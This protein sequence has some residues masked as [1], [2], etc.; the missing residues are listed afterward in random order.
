MLDTGRYLARIGYTGPREPVLDT[1]RALHKAHLRA[2]PFENLDIGLGRAIALDEAAVFDKIVARRRGGFCYELN[3]L[4]ALLLRALGFR[5]TLLSARVRR[6]GA[7]PGPDYGPEFDHLAL[8]VNLDEP[9]LADV[10]FGDA[11][12]L[13]LRLDARGQQIDG[14]RANPIRARAPEGAWRDCYRIARG[15][16]LR[17]LQRRDWSGAW[18]DQYR[19]TLTPR[20]WADFAGMCAYH[21]TAAESGFTR[22]RTCTLPTPTGRVTLSD[23]RLIVTADGA[24]RES[25]L[26]DDPAYTAALREHFGIVLG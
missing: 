7:E 6:R 5:V 25:P 13:P 10:G 8:R 16:P 12:L 20:G 11:F 18:Q 2:V 26:A 4:F 9:W 15:G 22:R 1:L 23:N 14:A 21:Q 3:G 17:T 24:R 19:F